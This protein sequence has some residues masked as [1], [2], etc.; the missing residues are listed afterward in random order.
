MLCLMLRCCVACTSAYADEGEPLHKQYQ[1]NTDCKHDKELMRSSMRSGIC[2]CFEKKQNIMAGIQLR[3]PRK[4][5]PLVA[6]LDVFKV[7]QCKRDIPS[8]KVLLWPP[9]T[10]T[11]FGTQKGCL[12][13]S[14]SPYTIQSRESLCVW[15]QCRFE[16]GMQLFHGS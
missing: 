2:G 8:E 11:G 6:L 13:Y 9:R 4:L 16:S 15:P 14:A 3:L 1:C 10:H 5:Q 12:A 7:V